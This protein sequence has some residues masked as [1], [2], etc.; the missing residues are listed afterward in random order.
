MKV[1]FLD[2]D[3]VL[4]SEDD[5]MV[6]REK[7]NITGCILYA[8]VEDRPLKLL[9]EIV[10][11]T[12]AKIV[13]SSSWRIGCERNGNKSIFGDRLYKKLESRLK[14]YDMDIYDITP[15]LG[16][17]S[18][19]GDEIREWLH[20]NPTDSFIILDDDTDM[21]EFLNTEH[22]I[23]TTYANGLTEELKDRA[24]EVLNGE[25]INEQYFCSK[26]INVASS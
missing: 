19:R 16:Y 24:I 5:L 26:S 21:C 7:N 10:D 4:N 23:Q 25:E 9:K 13:A 22:F 1:I 17:G 18:L 3:G 12:S 8:E 14:D 11:K 20:R 6:Y 15:S 2:V